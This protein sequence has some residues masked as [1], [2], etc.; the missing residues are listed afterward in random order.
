MLK[1]SFQLVYLKALNLLKNGLK[2][3]QTFRRV[4]L[5]NSNVFFSQMWT[6]P[7]PEKDQ[8]QMQESLGEE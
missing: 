5:K 2:P 1:F 4:L 6:S 8:E 3:C 7:S